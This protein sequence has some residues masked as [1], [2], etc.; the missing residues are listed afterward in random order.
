M[1][2]SGC[3]AIRC[4][5]PRATRS[6]ASMPN[7]ARTRHRLDGHADRCA[8]PGRGGGPP[9]RR[10]GAGVRRTRPAARPGTWST[11]RWWWTRSGR[12]ATRA[13]CRCR[14]CSSRH[15]GPLEVT[16][17]GFDQH[18]EPVVVEGDRVPGPGAA[19]RGRPSRGA[20][21][22]RHSQRRH[23]AAGAARGALDEL[24]GADAG[25]IGVAVALRSVGAIRARSS[26]GRGAAG[27][28]GGRCPRPYPPVLANTRMSPARTCATCWP[29]A[30]TSRGVQ[31]SPT[32]STGASVTSGPGER[33]RPRVD[34]DTP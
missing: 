21:L 4:C 8:G 11:R 22:H 28:R 1:R 10:T 14:G 3:S 29:R 34:R 23:P 17:H 6:P 33:V 27:N 18:G 2:P 25:L 20:P 26:A 24:G 9:D 13:A 15:R 5:V 19:A 16:A 7:C 30:S 32:A 31:S 12:A